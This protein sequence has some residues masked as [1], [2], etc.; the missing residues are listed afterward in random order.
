MNRYFNLSFTLFGLIGLLFLA[1]AA[2]A[3]PYGVDWHS[4]DGGGGQSMG[5]NFSI[6][7]T[8]GQP[9]AGSLSGGTF[10]INGGS[11]RTHALG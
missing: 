1:P 9:D 8:V 7:G 6:T 10:S 3:Q 5:G 2:L 11:C 4:V